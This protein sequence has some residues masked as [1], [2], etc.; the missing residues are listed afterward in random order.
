MKRNLANRE[1]RRQE[2]GVS[3]MVKAANVMEHEQ[4]K[5]GVL[6]NDPIGLQATDG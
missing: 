2:R 5:Q 3:P 6:S 1:K 4:M